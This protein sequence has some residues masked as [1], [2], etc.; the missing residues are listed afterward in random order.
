MKSIIDEALARHDE[1]KKVQ[2]IS[3]S[4]GIY[5]ESPDDEALRILVETLKINVKIV[6][7]GG[8]GSNTVNRLNDAGVVG[9]QMCAINTDANHLLHVHAPKKMLIGRR[10]TKGLGAGALPEVGEQ[11]ARENE[12]ELRAYLEGA[13]IV[14]V[15]AGMGGGTGTGSASVVAE[16]AKEQGALVMGI[17]TMP[18]K[19]E[20]RVRMENAIKG[21]NK[22]RNK[23]DTTIVIQND[24]LLELVPRLPLD[25]AFK[26]ADEILMNSIKG[27]TEIITKPGLVNLDYS[28]ML[29]VMENGGVAMVG[30]G[31]SN[32]DRERIELAVNEALNS[33]LLGDIDIS[34]SKGALIR[35][36]GGEDLTI[37]EA[38]AA[39]EMIS[40]RIS[41]N[42]RIIWGCTV[43]PTMSK[44]V[45]ILVVVTG[46]KSPQ[47]MGA[48]ERASGNAGMDFVH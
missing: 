28:D 3:K 32:D 4:T 31:S 19:A 26:V 33:P 21:L 12:D 42:A 36:V 39:A 30:I 34:D 18:F 48:D 17:V 2:E 43:D 15:T 9:A 7:C 16:M 6:G 13:N 5:N 37:S 23:C 41:P 1:H 20:G 46:V 8:G 44:D 40:A 47:L 24:K 14:F 25:A 11:A 27:M 22:L 38:Q 35:V 29:T 10:A 45:N